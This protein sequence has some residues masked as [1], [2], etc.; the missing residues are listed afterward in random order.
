MFA[1][2]FGDGGVP[3]FRRV[4][5]V[6]DRQGNSVRRAVATAKPLR[7]LRQRVMFL[8]RHHP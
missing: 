8:F 6:G 1:S 2:D 5:F 3:V 4:D 7:R